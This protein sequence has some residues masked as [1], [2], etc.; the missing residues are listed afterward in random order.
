MCDSHQVWFINTFTSHSLFQDWLCNGI[1]DL[2]LHP[3]ISLLDCTVLIW[4][5][6]CAPRQWLCLPAY[7]TGFVTT[8][9]GSELGLTLPEWS[10][11]WAR[12]YSH[13]KGFVWPWECCTV[14]NAR[15]S[16]GL[17]FPL[18]YSHQPLKWCDSRQ[19]AWLNNCRAQNHITGFGNQV[20]W[21]TGVF[22]VTSHIRTGKC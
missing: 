8:H 5:L 11:I 21:L 19:G 9:K 10:I 14:K 13:L 2:R 18:H 3:V 16:L 1:A 17:H 6:P 12:N 7:H 15:K 22:K 20:E 4:F